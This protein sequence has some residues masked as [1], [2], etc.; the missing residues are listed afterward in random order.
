MGRSRWSNLFPLLKKIRTS[1]RWA[2]LFTWLSLP[3]PFDLFRLHIYLLNRYCTYIRYYRKGNRCRL[4]T[5]QT[6]RKR[7]WC[8]EKICAG[9]GV[10]LEST[11][12]RCHELKKRQLDEPSNSPSSQLIQEH[13]ST[14]RTLR[15]SNNICCCP[16]HSSRCQRLLSPTLAEGRTSPCHRLPSCRIWWMGG[17]RH[18]HGWVCWME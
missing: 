17:C 2:Q 4:G 11:P 3:L 16:L 15:I 6:P 5:P 10:C 9:S 8:E 14:Q 18:Y 12:L 1:K 13:S 7:H